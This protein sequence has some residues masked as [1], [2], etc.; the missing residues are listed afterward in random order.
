[1]KFKLSWKQHL[2]IGL[3]AAGALLALGSLLPTQPVIVK[4]AHAAQAYM[5]QGDVS[6]ASTGARQIGGVNSQVP[7]QTLYTLNS[8]ACALIQQ[9]DIGYF[10]ALGF[11]PGTSQ[12]P[13]IIVTTGVLT[14]TTDFVVGVLPAGAYIQSITVV[15]ATANAVTG[16]ISV[17]STANGTDIVATITC[18]A[19][20]VSNSPGTNTL[21]KSVFT[22]TG[23]AATTI[24]AAAVTAWASANV[25]F[26]VL[27]AFF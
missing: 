23:G 20:C 3:L 25:T 21:V 5:C 18:G 11:S 22:A 10:A 17:G 6:G 24:H 4:P 8:N 27:Y 19:N 2:G 15:N 26:T 9:A 14:G 16:G 13:P 7:S 1:M 12:G